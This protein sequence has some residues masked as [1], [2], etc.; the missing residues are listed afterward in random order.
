MPR[1]DAGEASKRVTTAP[2]G[3]GSFLAESRGA[4]K[5]LP[6]GGT[7]FYIPNFTTDEISGWSVESLLAS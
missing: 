4:T 6:G 1:A 2:A 3:G 7:Q 5:N